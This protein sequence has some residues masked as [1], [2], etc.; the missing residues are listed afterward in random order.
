MA[1]KRFLTHWQ[2]WSAGGRPRSNSSYEMLLPTE[3]PPQKT[4]VQRRRVWVFASLGIV[5]LL[6]LFVQ[7]WRCWSAH[8]S[9]SRYKSADPPL[10]DVYRARERLL[11][12]HSLAVP[13][14]DAGGPQPK[15]LWFAN[16]GERFG[17]GNYLQETLLNAYLAYAAQRAF[18]FDDYTWLRGGP[19]IAK[20]N[21]HRIPARIPL[22]AL[23]SG[24]VVGG[25]M[26]DPNVP[27]SVS[28]EYYLSV[29]P[30]AKRVLLDSG[31][32]NDGLGAAPTVSQIVQRWATELSKIDAPCVEIAHHSPPLFNYTVTNTHRV[33]DV[34]P[35]L[36][37]SPILSHFGWSPLILS[38]FYTNLRYFGSVTDIDTISTTETSTAPLKGLLA[39]HIR[40]GDYEWWCKEAW[41]HREGFT[42][43][44]SF[45]EL[46]DKYQV[47]SKGRGPR[48]ES[49][50]HCLPNVEEIVAKVLEV[51]RNS[52]QVT[53]VYIMTNAAGPWLQELV[54]SLNAAREWP[55][56]VATSRDLELSWEG[57][58]VAQ[59][60]DMH[61]GQRAELFIGNGFSSL[62]SNVV[63]FRMHNPDLNPSDT[64]FW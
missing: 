4:E 15:F 60:V 17:W 14:P 32:V 57:K 37:Q 9:E 8:I 55:H 63:L 13:H 24:P 45:P 2:L 49:R 5:F 38:E 25:E 20:W 58:Y 51:A 42:G 11:P 6:G 54:T 34:F 23:I 46:P 16:H 22:S 40:R 3:H 64:H 19:D 28:R 59:A 35:A 61:V 50:K 36:S 43:F 1:L 52:G 18:V 41:W 12:Q 29:C 26:P 53:R 48:E 33:L 39:L 56:G 62:T 31:T 30:E 10:Y 7:S 44:N 21:G 27:R 47:L